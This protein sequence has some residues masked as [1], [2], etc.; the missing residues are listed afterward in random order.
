MNIAGL[1]ERVKDGSVK[2]LII[3][4]NPT[5]EGETTAIY[6][7]KVLKDYVPNITR[8]AYGLQMGGTLDYTDSLTLAKA[9]EGRRKI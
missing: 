4:T 1:I 5:I 6:L 3:A 2:E 9:I 7:S 8:L